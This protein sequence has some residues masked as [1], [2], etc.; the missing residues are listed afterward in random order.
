M[1]LENTIKQLLEGADIDMRLQ[2]LVRAGLMPANT[3]PML[4]KAIAKIQGGL[5][6]QG[7]EKDI[8]AN[9]LNAML[10]IVLGDDTVFN[11]ARSGAR[12][13]A[14]EDVKANIDAVKKMNESYKTTFHSA[15]NKYNIKSPSELDEQ[16]RKEF[17]NYV[18]QEFKKGEL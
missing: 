8:M 16:K 7:A 1:N 13:Y 2:Q 11:R 12:H 3:I 15:L 4:R 18:D 17:F 9:F 10:Y 5:P 6:L 14:N